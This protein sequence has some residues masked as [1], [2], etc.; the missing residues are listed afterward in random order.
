MRF[1]NDLNYVNRMQEVSDSENRT[2]LPIMTTGNLQVI[3][4]AT[5]GMQ[6]SP[7]IVQNSST[8]QTFDSELYRINQYKG[9]DV[10]EWKDSIEGKTYNLQ[11]K[12]VDTT[13]LTSG[14]RTKAQIV[15][16]KIV[17]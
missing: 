8:L 10:K 13:I 11:D 12:E 9:D 2:L 7:N 4:D 15:Q 17:V 14:L 16:S 6:F 3:G 5:N 1:I